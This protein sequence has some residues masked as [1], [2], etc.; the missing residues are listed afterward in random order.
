M[1]ETT[2]QREAEYRALLG[3]RG[4]DYYLSRFGRADTVVFGW[5]WSAFFGSFIWAAYRGLN[6]QRRLGAIFFAVLLFGLLFYCNDHREFPDAIFWILVV[7]LWTGVMLVW[8]WCGNRLYYRHCEK[9]RARAVAA[10]PDAAA[11]PAWLAEQGGMSQPWRGVSGT[12]F[13]L[14]LISGAFGLFCSVQKNIDG[15]EMVS[16]ALVM[17]DNR[18]AD[19]FAYYQQQHACPVSVATPPFTEPE[20]VHY[21]ARVSIGP[22]AVHQAHCDIVVTLAP[23]MPR[24]PPLA[25][26]TLTLSLVDGPQ[27][28]YFWK[29]SSTA[30]PEFLPML[31][32]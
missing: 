25:G 16:E 6:W 17:T 18:K 32:R 29:C 30:P 22:A 8:G 20:A 23:D 15:R 9:L 10:V 5:N 13:Y 12:P 24:A 27:G 21:I 7:I 4:V 2:A 11:R 3:R 1:T 19:V 26:T 31:C 28:A 14:L